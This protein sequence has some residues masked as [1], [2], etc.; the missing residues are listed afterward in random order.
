[1][2]QLLKSIFLLGAVSL[3]GTALADVTLSD[4]PAPQILV[5][6]RPMLILGGELGNSSASSVQDIRRIFPK[7]KRMNLNTVLTPVYWNLIEPTEGK[8][9][10][11]LVDA[12]I[13][14]ARKNDL[15]LVFLWF[16]AWKNSMS[17]YAPEWLLRDSKRF[18]RARTAEGKPLEIASAFSS[19]VLKADNRAF[20]KFVRHINEVDYDDTVLM[21]QIENEIGMLENARDHSAL[22][23]KNYAEGVPPQLTSFMRKNLK[24]LDP[25]L[26]KRWKDNGQKMSGSWTEVFGDDIFTDEYF[27]AWN[28]AAY[29]ERLARTARSLTSRPLYV[30]AA[31]NSRGRKPGEYPS[32][33]PLAHLKDIWHAAAPTLDLIA[34]DLYDKGFTDWVAKYA[35]PDN[36]L[37]IPEIRQ[38]NMNAAQ[39]LY[40]FGEYDA[41]G[42]S[43]FS[44][45]NGNDAP[46]AP[47]VKGYAMISELM[48]LILKNQGKHTMR[49][50]YFDKDSVTRVINDGKLRIT[51]SHYFTLPWDPRATDGS[52]WPETGAILIRTAPDEYIF[53]GCGTVVKFEHESETAMLQK[54]GE[55]GFLDSGADRK[56]PSKWKGTKRIGLAQV[57]EMKVSPD[58]S[59][60]P[61]RYLNGDETHQGRHVRICVDD[62]KILRVK[63]YEY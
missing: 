16:G 47:N 61:V 18:P 35:L 49:G 4:G 14:E 48:P 23:N 7:L 46:E 36:I 22:A 1:M 55:D 2:K 44:I 31:M 57:A 15:K 38:G 59:L 3:S 5:N 11:T 20:E 12:A 45:E 34:P 39:A 42:L 17:C 37:F 58:G 56:E 51:A 24:S 43:P 25:A 54:L 10:F 28:Y 41:I 8:M 50:L 21:F 60:T 63:L 53:A 27:M 13:D 6:G 19:E 62:F 52:E 33:G 29:V 26:A 9:D 30:N 32:A 40:V